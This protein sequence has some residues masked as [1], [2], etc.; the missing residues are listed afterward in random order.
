MNWV[1]MNKTRRRTESGVG[2]PGAAAS[3]KK[4]GWRRMR[5][6]KREDKEGRNLLKASPLLLCRRQAARRP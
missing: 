4:G 2:Q 1:Y 6:L 3:G 5:F